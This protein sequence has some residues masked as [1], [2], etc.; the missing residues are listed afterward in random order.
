MKPEDA[1]EKAKEEGHKVSASL[2]TFKRHLKEDRLWSS[3]KPIKVKKVIKKNPIIVI[4]DDDLAE[5]FNDSETVNQIL[6]ALIPIIQKQVNALG[7]QKQ[8]I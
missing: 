8:E 6:R 3:D 5:M 4:L 1:Y 2:A 7:Q